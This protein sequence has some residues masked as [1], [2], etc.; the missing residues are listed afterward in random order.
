MKSLADLLDFGPAGPGRDTVLVRLAG[1]SWRRFEIS[2]A[3]ERLAGELRGFGIGPGDV[4]GALM[5]NH[6]AS[7]VTMFGVWG[8]GAV[9][10]PVNPRLT[11]VE[12][13]AIYDRASPTAL[14]AP[15]QDLAVDIAERISTRGHE[16]VRADVA[17]LMSTSGTTGPPKTVRLGHTRILSALDTVAEKIG[18]TRRAGQP[19][20]NLIPFPL[21]LWSGIYNVCFAL[22]VGA[23]CVLMDRFDPRELAR[24]V[25]E[26]GIRS[27]VLAPGMLVS[28]LDDP[29]IASLEPL[30]FVRNATAP[31]PVDAAVRFH[32]RF[33]IPVLNG[34]GQTELGG[35][36]IG[37]NAVDIREFGEVKLGSIGRPHAGVA[38]KV[39]DER[40]PVP[41]GTVGELTV[42]SPFAM[43]PA[44]DGSD[45]ERFTE[46]GFIRTGDL[47]HVD[48]D[49]FVWLAGRVSDVIN[50]S[51]L[52]VF[53]DEVES[54]L[55]GSPDVGDVAVAGMPDDRLGEVPWAFVVPR[56]GRERWEDVVSAVDTKARSSLAAYKV[57]A[58]YVRLDSLPRNDI[59][60]VLRRELCCAHP[61]PPSLDALGFD[62][63]PIDDGTPADAACRTVL[64][65][66]D[67]AVPAAWHDAVTRGGTLELRTV[68]R[69][70]DYEEW[71]PTFGRSGLVA[72]TWPREYGGLGLGQHLARRIEE[73]LAP[74]NLGRLNVLGLNLAGPPLLEFGS[75]WQRDWFLPRS[76]LN[77][78]RWCQLFSE[79]GAGSDL[80]SLACSA[81]RSG[82]GWRVDGQKVWSTW[83]HTSTHGLLLAR[84][85]P[86]LPK[87]EG[88]TYFVVEMDSPG[89][90]VRPLV[91]MTGE[92]EFNEVFL[93]SVSV[94][95][96]RRIGEVGGGWTAAQATLSGERQMI[97][98]AGS[99]GVDRV[100]GRSVDRLVDHVKASE[101]LR[102]DPLVR[103]RL[104][105][106]YA[107][108]RCILWTNSRARD[109]RRAQRPG[110]ESSVGKLAQALRNLAV[111]E[112]WVDV[113]GA[114]VCA[115]RS[116][117]EDAA[118][119]MFGFLRSRAGTI[120]GGTSEIQRNVIAER[121]LGLP[122]EPDPYARLPW[123]D[124]PRG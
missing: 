36:V 54:V 50:R 97:S 52:K 103:Q 45:A 81:I 6:P 72:P 63:L 117:D 116:D 84:T 66:L 39:V 112:A 38:L 122:R 70:E 67:E 48:G 23:T 62:L 119:V 64:E 34:Y 91:Q 59:G 3:A 92:G 20:P 51:G 24:L 124:V 29:S 4:V 85:D 43:L 115:R 77:E 90:E 12:R 71:Y 46:D 58:R 49:G 13:N 7:V 15:R 110:P 42:L 11:Q 95:D 108:E 83:A 55:R 57:P 53:P 37:W 18:V 101:D 9:L 93:D 74:Y 14:L 40:G 35:E 44:P 111:Q 26:H 8:C 16:P 105:R 69:R 5:P 73:P 113:V 47:G 10:L 98:G 33:G 82:H 25:R 87:R 123:K 30:T 109:N 31:I 1:E 79:P 65:W 17:L 19:M 104:A 96:S 99:G 114:R 61:V 32:E 94:P 68:R 118:R 89:V 2:D 80:A 88:I 28:L 107:R 120:E 121:I 78:F 21:A 102:S 76:V 41:D 27:V 56:R 106:L 75:S 100:F 86:D 22:R 60:K